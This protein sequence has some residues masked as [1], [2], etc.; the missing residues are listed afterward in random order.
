M[1]ARASGVGRASS[2]LYDEWSVLNNV[3]GLAKVDQVSAGFTQELNP[4]ML[5]FSRTAAVIA[6]PISYGVTGISIFRFGDDLYNEQMLSLAF[7]NTFGITSIGLK[8]NYIQYRVDGFGSK[9]MLTISAGGVTRLTKRIVIGTYITNI[10]QPKLS[11][12]G[13]EYLPTIVA[14]GFGVSASESVFITT[15][16]EKDLDYDPIW[17]TGME[18]SVN[19]KFKSRVGFNL[20]P[21]AFFIGCGF[22]SSRLKVDYAFQYNPELGNSHQA[23]V[24]YLF[25][26][27]KT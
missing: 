10:N 24:G 23:T 20:N 16:I 4:S 17:K 9:G 3:G 14:A 27:R 5:S 22:I 6:V 2:C 7:A 18:Y 25:K 19:K 8:L 1:G 15:E 26:K 21:D 11:N 13:R 12:A